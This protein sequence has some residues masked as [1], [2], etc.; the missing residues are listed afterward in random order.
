MA[1]NTVGSKCQTLPFVLHGAGQA[2]RISFSALTDVRNIQ[3]AV[4]NRQE[5]VQTD[6]WERRLR[7]AMQACNC[8]L[9]ECFPSPGLHLIRCLTLQG[10]EMARFGHVV[11]FPEQSKSVATMASKID[12]FE[13][14]QVRWAAGGS[15]GRHWC[16]CA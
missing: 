6:E 14:F 10:V 1:I 7:R 4:S 12:T 16:C 5:W 13:S 9:R 11:L 2:A 3:Y 15:Q 8:M